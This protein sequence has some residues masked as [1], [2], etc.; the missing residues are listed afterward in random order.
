MWSWWHQSD[1]HLSV[2]FQVE[3][4]PQV[5]SFCRYPLFG[6]LAAKSS[7]LFL[8]S[9]PPFRL[10][11]SL[12]SNGLGCCWG[13]K[14]QQSQVRWDPPCPHVLL[15]VGFA[16]SLIKPF[17]ETVEG[18]LSVSTHK[19]LPALIAYPSRSGLPWLLL[20][21][22]AASVCRLSQIRSS[23]SPTNFV[24]F[25]R[26]KVLSEVQLRRWLTG[27]EKWGWGWASAVHI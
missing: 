21:F 10:P 24:F 2:L 7:L 22:H 5:R 9:P 26:H 12:S 23:P 15:W 13:G 1:A 18:F 16:W 4:P 14:P 19:L 11:V 20:S 3:T 6:L 25:L 8:S 27:G 17:I